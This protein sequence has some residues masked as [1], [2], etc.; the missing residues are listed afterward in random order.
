LYCSPFPWGR[1]SARWW[2]PRGSFCIIIYGGGH[3]M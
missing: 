3:I 1:S 2:F